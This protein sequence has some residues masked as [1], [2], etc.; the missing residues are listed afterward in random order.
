MCI[1]LLTGKIIKR[2]WENT[3]DIFSIDLQTVKKIIYSQ[4]YIIM[5]P[6]NINKTFEAKKYYG[7]KYYYDYCLWYCKCFVSQC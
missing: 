1:F 3:K 5:C 2:R 4:Y 7:V 6:K